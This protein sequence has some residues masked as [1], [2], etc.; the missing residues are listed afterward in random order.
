MVVIAVTGGIACGK[1][2]VCEMLAAELPKGR[3]AQF[4]SDRVVVEL[5]EDSDIQERI[6]HID[7]DSAGGA[8]FRGGLVQK[9]E[10]RKRAFENSH[11]RE[12]L[13]S[14]LHPLVLDRANQFR[15]DSKAFAD[16]VL[17]EV[18]LLYEVEFPLARDLD[19]V[20]AASAETQ[21]Q[22]LRK[23]RQLETE[24]ADHMI[25]AQLPIE[26]KIVR[27]DIVVWN[28]SHRD[29]LVEQINHLAERCQPLFN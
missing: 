23:E 9:V 1:S 12:K 17:M 4:C 6:E 28:D 26:E 8:L 15:E 13:E 2:S 11:F 19:L 22:R 18:P 14:V 27:G 21:R 16:V 20:V 5:L 25:G 3:V 24:M 10:L 7:A 29:V